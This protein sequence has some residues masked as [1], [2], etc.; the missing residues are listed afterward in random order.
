MD[1]FPANEHESEKDPFVNIRVIRGQ[2]FMFHVFLM[3]WIF[4]LSIL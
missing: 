3:S 1:I 2:F 4:I